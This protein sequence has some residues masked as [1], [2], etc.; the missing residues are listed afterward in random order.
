MELN[1]IKS[2]GSFIEKL[3]YIYTEINEE[4]LYKE[5]C[6]VNEIDSYLKLRGFVRIATKMTIY[7]WGDALYKRYS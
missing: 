7:K 3:D 2:F 4:K 1:V 5:C 6:L